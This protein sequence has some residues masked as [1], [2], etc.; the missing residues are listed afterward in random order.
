MP[1][2]PRAGFKLAQIVLSFMAGSIIILMIFLA[3]VE[4]RNTKSQDIADTAVMRLTMVGGAFP[5]PARLERWEDTI[6]GLIDTANKSNAPVT[7]PTDAQTIEWRSLLDLLRR[8]GGVSEDEIKELAP[9][10][11]PAGKKPDALHGCSEMLDIVD[12]YAMSA[13]GNL[14]KDR[15]LVEFAKDVD[16]HHQSFRA[17]F[18]QVAQMILLNL[19]LPIMTALL[20]Y[21]FGTNHASTEVGAKP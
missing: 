13:V 21:I 7:A 12:K 17:F 5:E 2:L 18:L 16:A 3:I 10:V 15:L 9:C 11:A 19:L 6:H 4:S 14:D 8:G 20:G 1:P